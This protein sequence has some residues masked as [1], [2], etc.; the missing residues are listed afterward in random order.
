MEWLREILKD[1]ENGEELYEKIG[2]EI[3]E[4]W[5][6]NEKSV[7]EYE[8]EIEDLKKE[9]SSAKRER[10]IEKEIEAQGGR[11]TKAIRALIEDDMIETDEEGNIVSIDM[12]KI[13]KSDPYLFKEIKKAVEG[14]PENKGG[15]RKSERNIFF[16]S[17]KKA[18]GIKE[19]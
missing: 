15:R 2:G 1:E 9:I 14:T 18:A 13:K 10:V 17:A 3:K 5:G 16:E 4:R 6:D 8:K 7:Q 11:N 19:Q 12:E